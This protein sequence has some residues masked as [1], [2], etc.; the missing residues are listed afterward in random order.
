MA[1]PRRPKETGEA[2]EA[3]LSSPQPWG[4]CRATF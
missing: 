3:P 1:S 4:T 2:R